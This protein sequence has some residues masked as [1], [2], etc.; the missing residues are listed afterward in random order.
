MHRSI[1]LQNKYFFGCALLVIAVLSL[2]VILVNIAIYQDTA[3]SSQ[4]NMQL[5][6]ALITNSLDTTISH[7]EDY[8]VSVAVD[9]R[10]IE[11]LQKNPNLP[12]SAV[13]RYQFRAELSTNI[14]SILG[15]NQQIIMWDLISQSGRLLSVSGYNMISVLS[16]TGDSFISD[17]R[18]SLH[19]Q[20][21]GPYII[22][23]GLQDIP[24]FLI[25]KAVVDLDT[26]EYYGAIVLVIR[27]SSL[28]SLFERNMPTTQYSS[29]YVIDSGAQVIC[30]SDVSQLL[31]PLTELFSIS[32]QDYETLINTGNLIAK[33]NG[34]KILF[35]VADDLNSDVT[36]RV[37]STMPLDIAIRSIT[38]FN[39]LV[40]LIA[41]LASLLALIFS[42]VISRTITGP[43]KR[44]ANTIKDAA[45]GNMYPI[46]AP[47]SSREVDVLYAG[48]NRLM[49]TVHTLV[50][51][52]RLEQEEKSNYKFQLIQAQIKPHFL[53]NTLETIKSLVDLGM[54]D[55][56]SECTSAMA[57][58]Y[59]LSLNKGIDIVTV[60]DEIELIR[61]YLYIQKLRY[62]DF[63]GYSIDV[64]SSMDCY[65]LPKMSLQP[66]LENAIYHGIKENQAKGTITVTGRE[67]ETE[68]VFSIQDDG[69]G[70]NREQ[71]Q[72]LQ[73][74][75]EQ[76][77]AIPGETLRSFGLVSIN[78]R[79]HLLFGMDYGIQIDSVHGEYTVI[80]LTL[81]KQVPEREK[82]TCQN[83]L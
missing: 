57:T 11:H 16:A 32:Q 41:L 58:F 60:H 66:I 30:S 50:S 46:E 62:I 1:S 23:Q 43:I 31:Q 80:T 61:Q 35:S 15:L 55:I 47:L 6:L 2:T 44:L 70:M 75:I 64:P 76:E 71:V 33:V 77:S 49:E 53:Y 45:E 40:P 83:L 56:A 72:R 42:Y 8:I 4:R 20:V 74:S 82:T 34:E 19:A 3:A 37:V 27:E 5:E 29:F 54:N 79:I 13:E 39:H 18:S 17:V 10:V 14:N 36:W 38:T 7:L 26:R 78:R 65:L 68:L 73:E 28:A 9:S 12:E 51:R 59:R 24:V 81:P 22:R 48:F 21:F 52:I 69:I 63:L 67:M 25:T